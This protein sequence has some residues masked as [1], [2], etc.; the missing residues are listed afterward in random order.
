MPLAL[1]KWKNNTYDQT[2]RC[3]KEIQRFLRIQYKK[4]QIKDKAKRESLLKKFV[5][6]KQK[7]NLYK[8][9]LPFS[10]WHKKTILAQANE[11]ASIIQDKFRAYIT[12]KHTREIL[13]KNKLKKMFKF[14]QLKN[15]LSKI[16]EAGNNKILN[17]N[18][19]SI[20]NV[21]MKKKAYT[22]DKS[23]LKRYFDKWR[24]Y[25][26]YTNNC[27]TR[28][29]NAFRTYQANKEKNR[30]K[31][32]NT[33]LSKYVNKHSKIDTDQMRSKLRK[34][35][36]KTKLINYN[37]S[38]IKLQRFM[39]PK[40]AKIRNQRFKKYFYETG[41]KKIKNLILTMAKFN[42]IKKSLE[43]P[44]LQRFINNLKK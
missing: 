20:L 39:R 37:M 19:K 14:N 24:Q 33:I 40:L 10:I 35:M 43:R 30:L 38:T 8:L 6:K 42:K 7:N 1:K 25:N 16:K 26:T 4:K 5:Q 29:A 21:I 13:A 18:R 36:N 11:S 27:V 17:T 3:T 22:D 9:Q 34:W 23:A 28:L 12:Q 15:I 44:S 2:V 41:E 32:L 31:K